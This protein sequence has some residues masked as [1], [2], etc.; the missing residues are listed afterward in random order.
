MARKP[1]HSIGAILSTSV[2]VMIWSSGCQTRPSTDDFQWS[3]I[4]NNTQRIS[5]LEAGPDNG[6]VGHGV[7]K[8]P[9]HSARHPSNVCAADLPAR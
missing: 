6:G 5:R 8:G 7:C 9:E 4:L 2:L 1:R 3:A